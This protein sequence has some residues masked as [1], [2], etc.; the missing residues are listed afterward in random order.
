LH[1]DTWD[2]LTKASYKFALTLL[3][4]LSKYERVSIKAKLL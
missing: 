1:P 4:V 2:E 3:I